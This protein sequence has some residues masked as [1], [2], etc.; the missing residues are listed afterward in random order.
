MTEAKPIDAD[1]AIDKLFQRLAGAYMAEWDR[2]LGLTPIKD[3]K[4]VWLHELTG[5]LRDSHTATAVAWALDHLPERA[6]NV[7]EFRNLC[8]QAPAVEVP[9]LEAPKADPERVA[10][11]LAKLAP[12]KQQAKAATY[13]HKGWAHDLIARMK[14]GEVLKPI[15]I[16]FAHEA[17]GL[18]V[19][20][21]A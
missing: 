18:K 19:G 1:V 3:V 4:T 17:L 8:R 7:I 15:Q 13:D 20:A 21:P 6:P 12:V 16:R 2:K 5:F 9:R 14:A 10:A 11:E